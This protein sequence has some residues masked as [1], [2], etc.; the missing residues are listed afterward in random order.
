MRYVPLKSGDELVREYEQRLGGLRVAIGAICLAAWLT[1]SI[2]GALLIKYAAGQ[3]QD[4]YV[5][6]ADGP[7]SY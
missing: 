5:G 1:I 2:G 6:L 7:Y 4:P 3:Q